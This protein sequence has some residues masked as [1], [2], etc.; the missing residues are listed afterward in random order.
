MFSVIIHKILLICVGTAKMKY[1]VLGY[2]FES[3]AGPQYTSYV[4]R[5][6]KNKYYP[7]TDVIL[8]S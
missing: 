1:K 5:F 8:M 3:R 6:T 7:A 4:N 2:Y